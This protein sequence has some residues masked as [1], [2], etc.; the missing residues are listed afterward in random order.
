MTPEAPVR[1]QGGKLLVNLHGTVQVHAKQIL[2][3]YVQRYTRVVGAISS[4]VNM[5]YYKSLWCICCTRVSQY[6][7]GVVCQIR[8]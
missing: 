2:R 8:L 5:R 1:L 6:S 7:N 4:Y 3:E